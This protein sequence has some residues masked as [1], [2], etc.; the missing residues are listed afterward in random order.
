MSETGG[1][2]ACTPRLVEKKPWLLVGPLGKPRRDFR[3]D[4]F[5]LALFELVMIREEIRVKGI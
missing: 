5:A 2:I 4:L 3:R 1:S